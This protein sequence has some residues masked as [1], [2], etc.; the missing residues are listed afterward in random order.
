MESATTLTTNI[1]RYV[2]VIFMA[3]SAITLIALQLHP[4]GWIL[5][6]LA[7][8]SALF[9]D[10]K[11]MREIALIIISLAILGLTPINTHIDIEHMLYM[12]TALGLAVFVPYGISRF[13]YRDHAVRF[14]FWNGRYWYKAEIGYVLFAFVVAFFLLPYYLKSTGSYLNWP[15]ATDFWSIVR[16][17]I[18]TNALGIWDELF[19]V[20]TVLG[21][22]RRYFPFSFANFLQAILFTSFLY[23]LGF[24]GWGPIMIFCFALL[25]GFIFKKTESLFYII[26]IHLTV[27]FILFLALIAAHHPEL[28]PIF[29]T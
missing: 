2:S 7:G 6:S 3:M 26:S 8:A 9:A 1:S 10:R 11:F 19:F 24:T 21:I 18:G 29:V 16:L 25:Q 15:S 27:D 23:E 5:L 13:V 28:M 20:S 12:G 17:F 14:K 22:L 4:T